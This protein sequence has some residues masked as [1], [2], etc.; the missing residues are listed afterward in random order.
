MIKCIYFPFW[1]LMIV[2][3]GSACSSNQAPT[4]QAIQQTVETQQIEQQS[5]NT[6]AG[7]GETPTS[8]ADSI[9]GTWSGDPG[10]SVPG[11]QFCT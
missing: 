1:M 8:L 2:A 5:E 11:P 3:F 10:L 9:L 6:N 4:E 7:N